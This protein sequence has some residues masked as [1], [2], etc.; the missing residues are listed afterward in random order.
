L[1]VSDAPIVRKLIETFELDWSSAVTGKP[2]A[3]DLDEEKS[4]DQDAEIAMKV[5]AEELHP[6]ANVVKKA[7]E[8]VVS[9]AGEEILQD[10]KVKENVKKVIKKVV[11]QA[12]KEAIQS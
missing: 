2:R 7:V 6:V 4:P 10:G 12:V 11:K 9:Q 1:I 3:V 5:L 8:N